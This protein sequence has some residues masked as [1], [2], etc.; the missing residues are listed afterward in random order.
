[1]KRSKVKALDFFNRIKGSD[2]N[3]NFQRKYQGINS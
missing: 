2:D 3:I 1:M